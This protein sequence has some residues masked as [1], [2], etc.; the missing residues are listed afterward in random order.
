MESCKIVLLGVAAAVIYGIL[1]DQVTARVCAEYFT[2]GHEPLFATEDPTLL[3]LGWGVVATWWVGVLLGV[4]MAFV[5]RA[6][7]RP[8]LTARDLVRPLVLGMGCLGV[9]ALLAGLAGSWAAQA[10]VL[11]LAG[12]LA[13]RVPPEKHVPFLADACAHAASY[14]GGMLAGIVLWTWAWNRRGQLQRQKEGAKAT[15]LAKSTGR[16]S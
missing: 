10:G 3:G 7:S 5:A 13:E 15:L 14:T 6:G 8:R 1:H 16:R 2:L 4:P 9:L 11:R 12:S